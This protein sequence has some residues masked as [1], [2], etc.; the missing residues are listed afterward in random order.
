QFR[1][2]P[3]KSRYVTIQMNPPADPE[4]EPG[5]HQLALIFKVPAGRNASN[6]KIN[7]GIAAPV[8]LAVPGRIDS[9]VEVAGLRAP[10]FVTRGPVSLVTRIRDTG[11]VHRDFRGPGRLHAQAGGSDLTFPD[12]TVLRGSTREVATRW[13]PP[14]M[15]V[16]HATVSVGGTGEGT[17]TA[18]VRIIVLPLHLLAIAL[19][20]LL[21]LL[22]GVWF[23]KRRFRARVLETA[24]ALNDP[25]DGSD[26]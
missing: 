20:S 3:G 1:L 7:R 6:I 15:C 11:T 26:L 14:L 23:T 8:F 22:L 16:C 2:E 21:A 4:P 10:G 9:S 13:N 25:R 24:A 19:G 18:T 12:F 5:D 17:R